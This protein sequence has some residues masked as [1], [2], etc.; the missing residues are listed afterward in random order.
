MIDLATLNPQQRAAVEH[1]EGPLL[2]LAGAGSGKTR[3]IT[4]RIAWLVQARGVAAEQILAVTFTNKAAREMRERVAELI[5][6]GQARKMT[7]STFH[8][9]C[10]AILRQHIQRLGYRRNFTI[11][12]AADQLRLVR[13]L[14]ARH[15]F[16]GRGFAAEQILWVISDCK[17]RLLAPEDF[18]PAVNDPLQQA[19]A[20]IYP[21]YQQ[22]LR[23]CNAVDFDDL[24]LLTH[25]LFL[26]HEDVLEQCRQRFR[27]I[28][29]DEYQDT[30]TA[31]YQLLRLLASHGNLC[32]VGDDDQSIYGWRGANLGN[33]LDF[34]KDFPGTRTIRL[35]QNYRSTG[36]I[37]EAAN[38][39]IRRNSRRKEKAL[40]TAGGAGEPLELIE[41]PDEEEE[42]RLVAERIQAE[43]YRGRRWR[44]MAILY[45][46]N[47]QSRP[48]EEQLRYLDIPYRLVGGQ[49]F[50][51][52]KEVKDA[53]AYLKVL[54][55]PRDEISLLRILNYPRRGIGPTSVEKLIALCNRRDVSLWEVLR[56][57]DE[58]G[59]T[60]QVRGEIALFVRLIDTWRYRFEQADDLQ[61]TVRQLF[62]ELG[63]EAEIRRTA[64][65]REQGDR[66]CEFLQD[67][68][69]AVGAYQNRETA[70]SL[71]GFLE[72]VSLLDDD[73]RED[74]E[75]AEDAVTLMSLHSSKGLE[76]P[77]VFLVGMEEGCLPHRKS[78][79][80]L[81]VEGGFDPHLEEER[82]LCYVGITRA[83]EKL[84]LT[85]AASR[86]KRGRPEMRE[87][88]R[89][90]QEIPERLFTGGAVSGPSPER[91]EEKDRRAKSFFS[92]I[93]S[94]LGD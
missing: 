86:R 62:D 72:K 35:E 75:D 91:E 18:H 64:G 14:L 63:L 70:P 84:V 77:L 57:P 31:Q 13:D 90:L 48:F 39:V 40:W 5:G 15:D 20:V 78:V 47:V 25:R 94:L 43:R 71:A 21:D 69:N 85:R 44:E 41:A 76:F 46:T 67:V 7:I 22:G 27:H 81:E 49:Q 45:R 58:A 9:L 93:Q 19:A 68:L 66:R 16:A 30:N 42:A 33:I 36:T 79:D 51:D 8:A 53:V 34:E 3:V 92:D 54:Y 2:L 37:L 83:R 88:S 59:L 52:R 23:A 82:R 89:F 50:F 29:V 4:F 1:G 65:S 11:Y 32:V 26:E 28:L 55:N 80:A 24:L 60:D 10:S 74:E 17:N 73:R 12:D 38:A 61:Q 87:P 56:D 6:S